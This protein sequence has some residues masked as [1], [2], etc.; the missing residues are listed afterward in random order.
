MNDFITKIIQKTYNSFT[1]I[2]FVSRMHP[3]H[4]PVLHEFESKIFESNDLIK[5]VN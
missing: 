5:T 2:N 4:S 1:Y 3:D